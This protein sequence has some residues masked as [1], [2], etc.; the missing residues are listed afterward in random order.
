[1][2]LDARARHCLL[3]LACL[4][5]F[6]WQGLVHAISHED[7]CRREPAACSD[8]TAET[9]CLQCAAIGA[10]G[11]AL[12]PGRISSGDLAPAAM[13]RPPIALRVCPSHPDCGNARA[14]PAH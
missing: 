5:L 6:Q 9:V 11:C 8:D 3:F 1:M 13:R 14:P 10:A 7:L 12:P 4:V 2:L